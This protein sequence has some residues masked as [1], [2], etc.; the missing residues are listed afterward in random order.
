MT[1]RVLSE[2][3]GVCLGLVRKHQPCTATRVRQEL[4]AAPS[5][6]WQASAGSVYPLL[7]RLQDEGLI[8]ANAD[9]AD[10]RGRRLLGITRQGRAALK[11]W[12]LA[13]TDPE[14]IYSVTDP[15]RS[16]TFFL[17]VLGETQ[18]AAYLN[19]LVKEMERYVMSTNE[20]LATLSR[21]DDVDAG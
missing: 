18:R 4:K 5:S 7:T 10:G 6:H 16:R 20:Y 15:M 19:E 3:E 11:K 1:Q 8:L 12:L 9:R 2:L 14:L 21:A 13:G 17:N